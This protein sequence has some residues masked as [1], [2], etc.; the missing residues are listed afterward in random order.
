MEFIRW[1]ADVGTA[2]IAQVGGKNASLGEM[3]RELSRQG[4]RVPN[5]F[6]VTADAFR[7]TLDEAGA[8]ARLRELFQGLD[9]RD[10]DELA[11]RA[12]RAR[13]IVYGATLPVEVADQIASAHA[14]SVDPPNT[15][16]QSIQSTLL[17]FSLCVRRPSYSL[18]PR[19]IE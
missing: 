9:T 11:R 2:D 12:A 7:R 5:G 16:T 19:Q 3:Y 17:I 18:C 4:V 15:H 14:R 13:D 8:W 10:V 1:F 6:A